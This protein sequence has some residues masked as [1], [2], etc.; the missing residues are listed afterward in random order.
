MRSFDVLCSGLLLTILFAGCV[1]NAGAK[2][3]PVDPSG[4]ARND[5]NTGAISGQVIDETLLPVPDA[6][7]SLLAP[8]GTA[9]YKIATTDASGRFAFSFLPA[10]KYKVEIRSPGFEIQVKDV[11]I[12][13]GEA[14]KEVSFRLVAGF[15]EVAYYVTDHLSKMIGGGT[16][17]YGFECST[18]PW[19]S[20]VPAGAQSLAGKYCVGGNTCAP[21]LCTDVAQSCLGSYSK[22]TTTKNEYGGTGYVGGYRDLLV[23]DTWKTQL[24]EVT[25]TQ[26]SAVSGRGVLF[27]VLGPNVTNSANGDKTNRCG[28]INQ[29]DP[30]DFLVISDKPPMRLEINEAVLA[31]RQVPLEDHCCDWRLRLFPGWCDLGNC[32]RWGP[33][34]NVLGV[35]APTR[36]EIFYTIFFKEPAPP[37]WTS[38]DDS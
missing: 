31:A 2:E 34:A 8:N 16:V 24:A 4:P 35:V 6:R 13:A 29:S 23:N 5:S 21:T 37:G 12:L 28:G 30:R 27:E 26:S 19:Y 33:D 36:V 7:A 38:L 22:D 18:T 3:L 32:A 11:E 10:G 14:A 15:A 1:A 9:V 20:V 25:W 17:K